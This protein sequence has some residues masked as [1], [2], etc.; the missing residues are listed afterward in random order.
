MYGALDIALDTYPYGGVTTTCEALWMGVPVVSL[1][2][3]E[4]ISRMGATLLGAVGHPE[5]AAADED[6][7]VAAVHGLAAQPALRAQLR[8]GLRA[9]MRASALCDEAGVTREL[10]SA[11]RRAWSRWCAA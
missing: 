11:Y 6:A 1:A 2:G 10:E 4:F 8:E 5:W 7:F 3:S 9:R